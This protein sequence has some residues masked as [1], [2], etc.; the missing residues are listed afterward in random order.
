MIRAWFWKKKEN[1]AKFCNSWYNDTY[2]L[3]KYV[4]Y[5]MTIKITVEEKYELH[6]IAV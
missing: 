6:K 2:I 1:V 4:R 3:E 5:K